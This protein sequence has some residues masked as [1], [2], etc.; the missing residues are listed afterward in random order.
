MDDCMVGR[1]ADS[2]LNE[3]AGIL[4]LKKNPSENNLVGSKK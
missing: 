3:S 4:P 1:G 2:G